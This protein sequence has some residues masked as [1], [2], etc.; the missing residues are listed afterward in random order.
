MTNDLNTHYRLLLGPGDDWAVV[1]VDLDLTAD[2]VIIGP[3]HAGGKLCRPVCPETR[4]LA[5]T[6][7]TRMRRHLGTMQLSRKLAPLILAAD[8]LTAASKRFPFPG[9]AEFPVHADI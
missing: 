5:D 4:G 7:P 6:A 3:R 1:D 2:R 9:Q 8:V